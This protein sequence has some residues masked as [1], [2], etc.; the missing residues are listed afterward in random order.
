MRHGRTDRDGARGWR[1]ASRPTV[2]MMARYVAV[3]VLMAA[4][5]APGIAQQVEPDAPGPRNRLE[6]LDVDVVETIR[7]G[8]AD[9]GFSDS[10]AVASDLQ[11]LYRAQQFAPLWTTRDGQPTAQAREALAVLADAVA[12]GLDPG[13][14]GTRRLAMLADG[15]D[16]APVRSSTEI[17]AFDVGL[18]NGILR[19]FR[20][21]HLG[22]IDPREIGFRL[23][24]PAD[25]HDFVRVLRAAMDADRIADAAASLRPPLQQ[26]RALRVALARYRALAAGPTPGP[27]PTPTSVLRPGDRY[28]GLSAL[29]RR[30]VAE[31]DLPPDAATFGGDIYGGPVVEGVRRFQR[32]YGL[33]VDGVVG[34]ATTAALRVP[35]SARVRQ[36]ELALERLRWLPDLDG[37]LILLNI[38]TFQ[39]WAWD[40]LQ[41]GAAPTVTMRAV[42]G[43][44]LDTQTPIFVEQMRAV[45]FRPYWN[46]PLSI[47]RD[48][49]LPAL[50]RDPGYLDEQQM[51]IV[52]GN[53]DNAEPVPPTP[54]AI[55]RLRNGT[56]RVR[57]RPGPRNALGLVKFDFPND[58][59]VYFH[60]TPAEQLFDLARRDFSHGCVRV[61][62]PIALAEWVLGGE[63]DWTRDRILEATAGPEPQ[64]VRLTRPVQV[65]LFYSTASIAPEDG[66]VRFAADIYGHDARLDRALAQP[67]VSE[68]SADPVVSH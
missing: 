56:L 14:Y 38:P 46:V 8:V 16:A 67:V 17:A 30:L 53:G 54:D 60:G 4:C 5:T 22:R 2:M 33:E 23:T 52:R 9:A 45:V 57:Q 62:S 41:S 63:P 48:E 66:A 21:L 18:S 43:R 10:T 26:Y 37:R 19:Y 25:G 39:V 58:E 15:L 32:R 51:E 36:I 55:G 13:A 3:F 47:L 6:P 1:Y 34:P 64:R 50:E 12:D 49:I 40:S 59:S 24:V 20:H 68:N 31:G 35:L 44:A 29:R 42:V 11:A 61:E 27:L 65:V 28:E 7:E